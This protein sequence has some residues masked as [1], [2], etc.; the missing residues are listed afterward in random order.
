ML[1]GNLVLLLS[2]YSVQFLWIGAIL[3]GFGFASFFAALFSYLRDRVKVDTFISSM[4]IL[5]SLS[6][7]AIGFPVFGE[8]KL[9]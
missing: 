9:E 4:L 6:G 1:I 5:S 3:I 7:N 8:F 2:N